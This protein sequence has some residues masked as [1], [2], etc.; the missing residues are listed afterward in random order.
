MSSYEIPATAVS[1]ATPA[2]RRNLSTRW[3]SG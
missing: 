3:I 1:P 2:L